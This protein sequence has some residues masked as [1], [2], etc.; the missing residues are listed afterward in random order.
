MMMQMLG[1]FAEYERAMVRE[2]T[3]AG[4][5]E[6]NA[7]LIDDFLD[8][9]FNLPAIREVVLIEEALRRTEPEPG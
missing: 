7:R 2:R 1:S 6:A 5:R 4:L 8:P 3:Q 9:Y